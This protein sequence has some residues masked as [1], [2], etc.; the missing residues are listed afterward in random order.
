MLFDGLKYQNEL[1]VEG[2][3]LEVTL[4]LNRPVQATRLVLFAPGTRISLSDIYVESHRVGH[5][6]TLVPATYKATH[7]TPATDTGVFFYPLP[8]DSGLTDQ[9]RFRIE[10]PTNE[11]KF[12]LR[13]IAVHWE[14]DF[15]FALEIYRDLA[16]IY[17][18][19]AAPVNAG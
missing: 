19:P 2:A 6:D 11:T 5:V 3:Q 8:A 4:G 18:W 16:S 15:E 17:G 10:R 13:E 7:R 14:D 12:R 1:N 9:V